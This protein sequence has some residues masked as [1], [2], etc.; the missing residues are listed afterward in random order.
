MPMRTSL[1]TLVGGVHNVGLY[2]N[3]NSHMFS[4]QCLQETIIKHLLG[5]RHSA[6]SGNSVEIR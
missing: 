3:L 2:L 4:Y 5:A 1:Y 6:G